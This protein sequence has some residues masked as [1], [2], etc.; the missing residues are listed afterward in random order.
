MRA[1]TARSPAMAVKLPKPESAA[2]LYQAPQ[3]PPAEITSVIGL[4]GSPQEVRDACFVVRLGNSAALG[5]GVLRKA[6]SVNGV[7]RFNRLA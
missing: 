4:G 7:S 6:Q 2:Q 1:A 3:D 5:F